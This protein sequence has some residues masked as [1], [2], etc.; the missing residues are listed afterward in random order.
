MRSAAGALASEVRADQRC[1]FASG[2]TVTPSPVDLFLECRADRDWQRCF[3]KAMDLDRLN[4]ELYRS[5]FDGHGRN[6]ATDRGDRRSRRER[7]DALRNQ[8]VSTLLV[9][10][11]RGA[12][13]VSQNDELHALLVAGGL[14]KTRHTSC[15]ADMPGKVGNRRSLDT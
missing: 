14:H 7:R 15:R 13:A 6:D 10:E 3:G 9:H 12:G 11:L 5:K 1:S 4:H 2:V 8:D